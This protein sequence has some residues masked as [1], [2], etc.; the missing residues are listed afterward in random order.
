MDA[1]DTEVLISEVQSRPML[2]NPGKED[3]KNR[4][5]RN[6]AWEEICSNIIPTFDE[7][8]DNLKKKLVEKVRS[9]W[10]S[11]RD[12]YMKAKG[13]VKVLKSGSAPC[14]AIR[15]IY[16]EQMQFL[17]KIQQRSTI[18]NF[19]QA[20]EDED[21]S[22]VFHNSETNEDDIRDDDSDAQDAARRKFTESVKN[23]EKKKQK[24]DDFGENLLALLKSSKETE[25]DADRAFLLSLLPHV[26]GF[27]EDQKLDFQSGVL[28][29]ITKIKRGNYAPP[30]PI[31]SHASYPQ[32]H[33]Y[34]P[35]PSQ[36][37]YSHKQQ[38]DPGPSIRENEHF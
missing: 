4:D 33:S 8:D 1:I 21:I 2:W 31:G 34:N 11:S 22:E 14:K 13:K 27:D 37:I 20:A 30:T 26:R 10:K 16:Y 25:E 9:R 35:D 38:S 7:A 6:K 12:S 3:Y 18:S 29:L 23:R 15:Y 19:E 32:Y 5:L 24:L 28:Q 17:D 36:I